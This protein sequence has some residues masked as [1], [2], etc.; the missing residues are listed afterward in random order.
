MKG[1]EAKMMECMDG[2]SK[3]QFLLLDDQFNNAEGICNSNKRCF[4]T[5]C[6]AYIYA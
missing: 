6:R 2:V 4:A 5:V 1:T 3:R